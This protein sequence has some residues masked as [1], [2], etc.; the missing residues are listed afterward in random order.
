MTQKPYAEGV[1]VYAARGWDGMIPIRKGSKIPAMS[2][3]TGYSGRQVTANE[4]ADLAQKKQY[5][6][7]NLG[8]RLPKGLVGVDIDDYEGKNGL[9]TLT[10]LSEELGKLPSTPYST[11]R[12]PGVSGIRFYK[13]PEDLDFEPVFGPDIECI[14]FAHR[15]AVAWPSVHPKTQSQYK[16]YDSDGNETYGPPKPEDFAELPASWVERFGHEPKAKREKIGDF[17]GIE[18]FFNANDSGD[19]HR[20]LETAKRVFDPSGG[21]RHDSMLKALG[22]AMRDAAAGMY[23]ARGAVEQ[24]YE[25]WTDATDG[26]DREAEFNALVERAASDAATEEPDPHRR[27]LV[28]PQET[29]AFS[30]NDSENVVI[31]ERQ[32]VH[33]AMEL[34]GYLPEDY[35]E[36]WT[37]NLGE[38]YDVSKYENKTVTV[39]LY[40]DAAQDRE[41]YDVAVAFAQELAMF[42]ATVQFVSSPRDVYHAVSALP[43]SKRQLRLR[44]S[45]DNATDSPAKSKP[46]Y[47]KKRDAKAGGGDGDDN[48]RAE[49]Q[50]KIEAELQGGKRKLIEL[51]GDRKLDNDAIMAGVKA[52]W[53]GRKI[54]NYGNAISR[55]HNDQ[56]LPQ[57]KSMWMNTLVEACKFVERGKKDILKNVDPPGYCVAS[58]L[59]RYA[60]FTELVGIRHAPFIR[61]DGTVCQTPGYDAESKMKLI[62]GEGLSGIEI[63]EEPT[64]SQAVEARKK[65][66][67]WLY[68]FFKIMPSETDRANALAL[69]LT[70]FIRGSVPVVPLCVVNGLQH[71]VGKNKFANG[72][73]ILYTGKELIPKTFTAEDEEQRKA[74]MSIFRDGE[75]FVCYDEAHKI[76][77][78][79]LA[80][81]LTAQTWSDRLLGVSQIA[82]YPNNA[83]WLSLGNNVRV[84]GDCIRRVYQ[85]QLKPLS[86][87]PENRTSS[88]F[89]H[90]EFEA[91]T[92][93]VRKELLVAVLTLIRA[94]YAAGKPRPSKEPSFGSYEVW[95]SLVRGILEYAGVTGFL[96]NQQ[97]VR[98]EAS[99]DFQF[100]VDHF[101]WLDETFRDGEFTTRDVHKE[102]IQS[103]SP[104]PP[105]G[106]EDT[107]PRDYS[108]KLGIQYARMRDRFIGSFRLTRSES[109][110]SRGYTWRIE[111][112]DED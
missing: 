46:R 7:S 18:A 110:L 68:D 108:R 67:Y 33:E 112:H 44:Q 84:E 65:L 109:R 38:V 95:E 80:Q 106:L 9:A 64:Q 75:D 86:P 55:V 62:L 23:P 77:G 63:P 87:N 47:N 91:W 104:E 15:F 2:D 21:S 31:F 3:V 90:P 96:G 85:I 17:Y 32:N 11:A 30:D 16:W 5:A 60:D 49:N 26:E 98:G 61:N 53:D 99:A 92:G 50:K 25:L 22:C 69:V 88:D 51:T 101:T 20:Y 52:R 10:R 29:V 34:S 45:I 72:I 79:A 97:E 82:E 27:A 73:S 83:T 100:W 70:P 40:E 12:G 36:E 43:E 107:S 37:P 66:E 1:P 103:Q 58:T 42:D 41:T 56:I 48:Y 71:G 111:K 6:Y 24:L 105:P 8:L 78:K 94:W 19:H 74:L 14:R 13:V 57:D 102:L 35:T 39:F 93:E 89:E 28:S 76:D 81:A 54:F 4:A 59:S